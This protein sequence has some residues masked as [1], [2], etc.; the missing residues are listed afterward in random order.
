MTT[1]LVDSSI[2]RH[3]ISNFLPPRLTVS[4]IISMS[5]LMQKNNDELEEFLIEIEDPVFGILTGGASDIN[6]R[7][8]HQEVHPSTHQNH[9]RDAIAERVIRMS[10]SLQFPV[11]GIC[12]GFQH[13]WADSGGSLTQDIL[14]SPHTHSTIL[15]KTFLTQRFTSSLAH[16][17]KDRL[18][19]S[20]H[21]QA[22]ILDNKAPPTTRLV[23]LTQVTGVTP[24]DFSKYETYQS[25]EAAIDFEN[26]WAG[27]QYH[28]EYTSCP[29]FGIQLAKDLISELCDYYDFNWR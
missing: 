29:K 20:L 18:V 2:S 26:N 9:E 23:A 15:L 13:L 21:H 24:T 17:A 6:P 5:N 28:P 1:F 10:Q 3:E 22:V 12:R 16:P 14:G 11:F 27:V 8:Y 7:I 19:N 4:N 25:V